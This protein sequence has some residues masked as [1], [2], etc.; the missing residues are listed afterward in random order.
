MRGFWDLHV[1]GLTNET[2]GRL[3]HPKSEA[4]I[5]LQRRAQRAR[6]LFPLDEDEGDVR[7]LPSG[8]DPWPSP[9]DA[10]AL[11]SGSSTQHCKKQLCHLQAT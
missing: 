11:S 4:L 3:L 2:F 7:P 1:L 10:G 5:A 9:A 6:P 8:P